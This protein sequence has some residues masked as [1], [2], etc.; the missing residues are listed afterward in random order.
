MK[1]SPIA[2]GVDP[3]SFGQPRMDLTGRRVRIPGSAC[4][5]L[6]D[7]GLRRRI[8]DQETHDNLFRDGVSILE[9]SE[10]ST[11]PS[12]YDLSAGALLAKG[13]GSQIYLVEVGRKRRILN[14]TIMEQYNFAWDRV[15][16]IPDILLLSLADGPALRG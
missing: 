7:D 11:I 6:V 14:A 9:S 15:L 5:Y 12:T 3:G 2:I 13:S 16:I 8:P 10:Y 4:T 1:A